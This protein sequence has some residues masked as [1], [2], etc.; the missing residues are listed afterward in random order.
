MKVVRTEP[1]V[2]TGHHRM[3]ILTTK[4]V[5][6]KNA[7]HQDKWLNGTTVNFLRNIIT[8]A[9]IA[10]PMNLYAACS[11]FNSTPAANAQTAELKRSHQPVV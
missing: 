9:A 4:S 7:G 2:L 6:Y 11:F 1:E 3:I 5:L 8:I 10:L